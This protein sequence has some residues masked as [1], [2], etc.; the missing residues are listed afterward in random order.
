M[1]SQAVVSFALVSLASVG[2]SPSVLYGPNALPAAQVRAALES[3]KAKEP[4]TGHIDAVTLAPV[5]GRE[6]AAPF[7]GGTYLRYEGVRGSRMC[8]SVQDPGSYYSLDEDAEKKDRQFQIGYMRRQRYVLQ[9]RANFDDLPQDKLLPSDMPSE[10]RFD[11][12]DYRLQKIRVRT[13]GDGT[14][15]N[16][17]SSKGIACAPLP[18]IDGSTRYI[19]ITRY[20]L[21]GEFGTPARFYVWI[22]DG[23]TGGASP[24][25]TGASSASAPVP[26]T[27]RATITRDDLVAAMDAERSISRFASY[28][29]MAGMSDVLRGP[30]PYTVFAAS[31]DAL[32][33][34]PANVVQPLEADPAKM[35][36]FISRLVIGGAHPLS[37]IDGSMKRTTLDPTY[38]MS[39]ARHEDGRADVY[40]DPIEREITTNNGVLYVIGTRRT[41]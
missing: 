16:E 18:K 34:L 9:A 13:F 6:K 5:H 15:K 32:A 24:Q 17:V 36:V 3:D 14:A 35:K 8:F 12:Y 31:N 30:G 40:G 28:V 22:L 23:A 39:V 25:S 37:S 41:P 27:V 1:R 11:E 21:D 29:K 26:T 19:T 38:R 4:S 10:G 7:I 20:P 2:C 33:K